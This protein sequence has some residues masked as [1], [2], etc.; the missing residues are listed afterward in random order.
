LSDVRDV[1]RPFLWAR[2][3]T[4]AAITTLAATALIS[5]QRGPAGMAITG[6]VLSPDGRPVP[7]TFVT[8]LREMKVWGRDF[9]FVSAQLRAMTNERGEYRLEGLYAGEFFLVA[10]PHNPAVDAVAKEQR[11]GFGNTFYPGVASFA[12]AKAVR[13]EP[14][15]TPTADITLLPTFVRAVSGVVIGSSDRPVPGARLLLAH[16]DGF[17]GL[18]TRALLTGADGGF[19]LAGL[20]PGTYFLQFRE[21]QWP[22]PR[23]VI[24]QVSQAKVTITDGDITGVRVVPLQMVRGSGRII[25]DAADRAALDVRTVKVSAFPDPIDGNPGP[26]QV[27]PTREDL[28]FAFQTWPQPSRIRVI[29]DAP[30]WIVKA[31][32]HNGADITDKPIEFVQGEEVTG[33]EVVIARGPVRR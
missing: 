28:T 8:A 18:D 5:A 17:F 7:N 10:L 1:I 23:G 11:T 33:L 29:I 13:V 9:G 24:P 21:S 3:F 2:W 25:V 22:P 19:R 26:Q 27:E 31:V 15:I 16:G 12:D 14:G 30:G 4:K 32:R 6:R 20:Q